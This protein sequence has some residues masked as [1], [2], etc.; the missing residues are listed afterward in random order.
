MGMEAILPAQPVK[1]FIKGRVGDIDTVGVK[2]FCFPFRG[3]G[4]NGEGHGDPVVLMAVYNGAVERP[5]AEIGRA[6]V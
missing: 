3:Q 2:D 5:A 4:G 6:H 1:I